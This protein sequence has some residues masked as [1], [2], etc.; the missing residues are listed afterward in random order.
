MFPEKKTTSET[1]LTEQTDVE[2]PQILT[3]RIEAL[4]LAKTEFSI[5]KIVDLLGSFSEQTG[6]QFG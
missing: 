3:H 4:G 2:E 1:P 6:A 5:A